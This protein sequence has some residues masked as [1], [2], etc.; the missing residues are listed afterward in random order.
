MKETLKIYVH[1]QITESHNWMKL[2]QN[3]SIHIKEVNPN[4]KNS[5]VMMLVSSS[6]LTS[7]TGERNSEIMPYILLISKQNTKRE[8]IKLNH[9]NCSSSDLDTQ[10]SD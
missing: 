1:I 2:T 7:R 5:S 10:I 6:P 8:V 9:T 3:Q 4:Y